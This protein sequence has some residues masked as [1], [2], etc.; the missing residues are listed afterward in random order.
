MSEREPDNVVEA[1]EARW[2]AQQQSLGPTDGQPVRGTTPEEATPPATRPSAGPAAAAPAAGAV[3]G[4]AA[5]TVI[6]GPLGTVVGALIGAAT[7]GA[8]AA[9]VA[10]ERVDYDLNV[11]RVYREHYE[12]SPQRLADRPFDAVRP[13]YQFGHVAAARPEWQG[14]SFSD[15]EAQLASIWRREL[16]PSFG[17]WDA[18]R[19]YAR[20]AFDQS[21]SRLAGETFADPN[22]G[23]SATHQRA[24]YS[25]P[26]PKYDDP[27]D[28]STGQDVPG[29]RNV[30]S[31][32]RGG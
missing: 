20:A 17:E 23:G 9:A 24:S 2:I 26:I 29:S 25:D 21:R 22:L 10:R 16:P 19:P 12:D 5:G 28:S 15:I 8:A 14:R 18:M 11:D 32:K 30:Q 6:L 31:R 1:E 13:A 7:G 27:A 3:A 4:G